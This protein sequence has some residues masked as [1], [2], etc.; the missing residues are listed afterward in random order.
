[1]S[2]PQLLKEFEGYGTYQVLN[3]ALEDD[4]YGGTLSTWTAGA[5]FEATVTL[6]DSVQMKIA[7]AQGVKGVYRVAT[8]KNVMLPWHTVFRHTTSGKTYRVTT[9]EESATPSKANI[10]IRYVSAED[11]EIA[12]VER[13]TESAGGSIV[14]TT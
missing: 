11:Y 3:F 13:K 14:A 12:S 6:D 1:M 2:I 4:G 9:K 8:S 5:T 10:D 7:Q